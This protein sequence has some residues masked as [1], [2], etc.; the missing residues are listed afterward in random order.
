MDVSTSAP[1]SILASGL[2]GIQA[3]QQRADRAASELAGG[4]AAPSS[5]PAAPADDLSLSDMATQLVEL[6][7]A[8]LEV[9]AGARVIETA[10]ELLGTL[11]N[12][13]A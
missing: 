10:D 8:R 1:S 2:A 4:V 5:S 12:T 7:L 3:G 13:H 6:N 9:E 11:V